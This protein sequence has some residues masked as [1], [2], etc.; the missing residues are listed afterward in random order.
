MFF[1]DFTGADAFTSRG[2]TITEAD[3]VAFAGLSGD[4]VEIHTNE[5]YARRTP[6]GRRVAHG[7]LIF[8]ISI[9]LTTQ[10]RL[11]DDSL[12]AFAGV[13]HLRFVEPVFI[14]DTI[15]VVK[16]PL[17]R[18]DLGGRGIVVFETKVINQRG[19]TVLVYHDKLLLRCRS[20]ASPDA[21]T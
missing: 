16:Q 18:K 1:E 9:G 17:E 12:V 8:S 2:R 21:T 3:I 20:A 7:A 13:D 11:V 10:L 15:H 4:Y 14:N 5:E 6:F 19:A